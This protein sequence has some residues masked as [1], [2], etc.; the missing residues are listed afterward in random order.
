MS[1]PEI[2]SSPRFPGA[3]PFVFEADHAW[4]LIT[5]HEAPDGRFLPLYRSTDLANW[6]FVRGA[7]EAGPQ[8]GS[9]NRRNFWAPEVLVHGGRFYCYYTAMPEGTPGNVGN[10]VGLAVADRP[11]GPYEDCGV[12][13][14]HGSIDGSP[15]I[16]ASGQPWILFTTEHGNSLRLP[17]GQIGIH[18]LHPRLHAVSD[19]ENP[20]MLLSR[21]EWQEGAFF[22]P[23]PE[24]GQLALLFSHGGWTEDSYCVH[25]AWGTSPQGP[26]TPEPAPFLVGDQSL[27]GPGHANA[28]RGISGARMLVF[29]AWDAD[30]TARFPFVA[31]ILRG[32]DGFSLG[33]ITPCRPQPAGG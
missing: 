14:P 20:V 17:P 5:S 11:D 28:F 12:V 16:D 2:P 10:R 27:R 13:I 15:F 31:P 33:A 3:D 19:P 21:F 1:K 8:P 25:A 9:W 7:V 18:R 22:L 4:W 24:S 32:S 30:K 6:T 26:F 29:H 23:F